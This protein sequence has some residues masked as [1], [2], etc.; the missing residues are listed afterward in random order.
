[1]KR[2][3]ISVLLPLLF[4]CMIGYFILR[5]QIAYHQEQVS[6]FAMDTY[7]TFTVYGTDGREALRLAQEKV[8]E[9]EGLW[10]VTG[11]DSEIHKINHSGGQAV[12]VSTETAGLISFAL[13]MAEKT[14][15]ALEPT[16]YPVLTAWGFTTE[17]NRIPSQQELT[18]L[19]TKVGYGK[20]NFDGKNVQ[21]ADG[22]MLD[23]GAVGKGY[24]GD[25]IVSLLKER[26]VSSALLDIGGNIQAVG[27][28]PDG[29]DWQ[30]GLRDPYLEGIIGVIRISDRAVVTS[31]SYER[32]FIGEDGKHYGHIIDP[33][34]GYPVENDLLSVTVIA[35]EGKL[36]DALS[37][38]LFVMG[39][40][41]AEEYWHQHRDFDMILV[42]KE[43][44][45]YLTED[46]AEKFTLDESHKNLDVNVIRE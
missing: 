4:L 44:R 7:M 38:S 39:Q 24:A 3:I 36:C 35:G 46:I 30:V 33:V 25:E 12:E 21:L 15:G 31:G 18:Q 45:I 40:E 26:G 20:V 43:G 2:R 6:F 17:E 41:K 34:T 42:T 28:K 19:L 32:Y 1:M 5:Q 29:S 23:I 9:L 37:T 10:S 22:M 14:G 8:T 16:I 27:S 13:S 11:Q